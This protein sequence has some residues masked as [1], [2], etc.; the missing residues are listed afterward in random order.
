[1]FT[2]PHGHQP[3]FNLTTL[4]RLLPNYPGKVIARGGAT[5]ESIMQAKEIGFS[6]IAFNQYIWNNPEPL[7]T[8]RKIVD[9]FH[10]LG[11][12]IE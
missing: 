7:E 10:E 8:F 1:M 12:S 3:S 11:L 4:K 9:R 6:G 2:N 5:L